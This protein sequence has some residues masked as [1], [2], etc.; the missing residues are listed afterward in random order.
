MLSKRVV[1]VVVAVACLLTLVPSG[2]MGR[3][4]PTGSVNG[5]V[6][7]PS[8]ATVV[9]A[10]ITLIDKATNT[11]RTTT[12][13]EAGRYIF[14]NVDPG[15][16]DIRVSMKGFRQS[17]ASGQ[18]VVV[19]QMLTVNMTLEIGAMSETVEVKVAVGAELQT[20]NA[21]MGSTVSG[22]MMLN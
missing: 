1:L 18:E 15:T 10:T 17:V 7:D 2:V 3:G 8:G 13:N 21:T 11:P 9:G 20:E 22:D 19:G 4:A 5:L 12:A 14:A 16:Y 6:T